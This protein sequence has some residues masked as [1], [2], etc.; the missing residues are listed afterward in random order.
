[1]AIAVTQASA[2][3]VSAPAYSVLALWHLLSLDAPCVA[4]LWTAFAARSFGVDLPWT[5]PAALALAVW[6]LYAADRLSDAARGDRLEERHRFHQ[7]HRFA[8]TGA[9]IGALPLLTLLVVWLPPGLRM[10]WV[11]LALPMAV[12]AGAV[13]GLRLPRVPKEHLVGIFFALTVMMPVLASH[14]AS[15]PQIVAVS[16]AFGAVCWLN[17]AA[18]ARWEDSP[19]QT[20]DPGTAWATR[21][22]TL[23]T[24]IVML[25]GAACSLEG[26]HAAC[27]GIAVAAGAGLLLLL[28][29]RRTQVGSLDLRSLA[30]AALLTPLLFLPTMLRLQPALV[31]IWLVLPHCSMRP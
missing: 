25:L 20:M 1:V 7:R 23:A 30:D 8:F 31:P 26:W 24:I 17:C 21:S 10:A 19:Q 14:A 12:Y 28:D 18:I 4:A 29:R 22:F 16:V 27:I 9:L 15:L 2:R 11:L 6:M 5:A 3:A 13:H